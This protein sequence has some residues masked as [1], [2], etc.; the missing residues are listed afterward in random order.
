MTQELPTRGLDF[1]KITLRDALD[2]ALLVEEEARDRYEE[3]A[4]QLASHHTPHAAAFFAKMA[5]VEEKHRS[6][7]HA[8]RI[9]QFGN[10]PC[11]VRREMIFDIEAPEYHEA[12]T[13][14]TVRQA[15]EVA[16]LSEEKAEAFFAA[17][18]KAV[19]DPAIRELFEELRDEE[20]E[21]QQLV[22]V[23]IARVPPD[24]PGRISDYEDEPVPH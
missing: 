21:H 20:I 16:L 9:A 12:R 14:M 10:Q 5:R 15:L 8:R 7:L 1:S 13:Y 18:L 22:R 4:A 23:E 6:T 19:R 3:F 2:L 11:A 17:A 24:L